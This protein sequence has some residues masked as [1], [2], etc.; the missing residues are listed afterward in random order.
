MAIT[1]QEALTAPTQDEIDTAKE[2]AEACVRVFDKQKATELRASDLIKLLGMHENLFIGAREL[3][4]RLRVLHVE[5]HERSNANYY[6]KADF[7]PP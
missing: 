3:K 6:F 2:T 4:K 5:N 7:V 1:A